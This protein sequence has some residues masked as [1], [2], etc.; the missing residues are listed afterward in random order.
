MPKQRTNQIKGQKKINFDHIGGR[1]SL[2]R[3]E[4][5]LT[6]KELGEILGVTGPSVLAAE[7]TSQGPLVFE[8]TIFF[9]ETF[10][11][12]PSWVLLL[13]NADLPKF[14]ERMPGQRSFDL[15]DIDIS[16]KAPKVIAEKIRMQVLLLMKSVDKLM[17]IGEQEEIPIPDRV[18]H[19]IGKSRK[20]SSRKLVS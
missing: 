4:F 11:I 20:K 1:I 7:R 2:L 16:I 3:K 8:A 14:L 10:Q 15:T 9:A 19:P 18:R 12:N 13:D 6:Q 5:N 17:E